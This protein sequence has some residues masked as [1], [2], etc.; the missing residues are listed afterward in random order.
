MIFELTLL[1]IIIIVLVYIYSMMYS[2]E[3]FNEC[4]TLSKNDMIKRFDKYLQ[5]SKDTWNYILPKEFNEMDKTDIYILDVRRP[6]DYKK[7]H[8]KGSVNIFWLDIMKPENIN[9]IP[10]D[11]QIVIVCYV[12]H[13]SSQ[14][15]V[16]L[17]LLGYNAKV[18]KFG[19]GQSPNAEVPIAGWTNYGFETTTN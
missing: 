2:N 12:G 4:T 15:L 18:L 11:K 1:I 7:G 5:E 19:M 14:V 3:N 9:K 8:I 17:K 16:L 10:I 13:T 6:E